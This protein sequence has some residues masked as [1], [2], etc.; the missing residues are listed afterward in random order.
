VRFGLLI[1]GLREKHGWT[2]EEMAERAGMNTSYLGFI[3]RGENV[4]TLTIIILLAQTLG[5][6]AGSLVRTVVQGR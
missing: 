5:V 4:P 3:E 1:R 2:R 6:D